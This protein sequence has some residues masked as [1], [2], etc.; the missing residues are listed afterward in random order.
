MS[1]RIFLVIAAE[2]SQFEH[3]FG[4]IAVFDECDVPR[5]YMQY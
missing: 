5:A 2:S 4:E 1:E 3:G